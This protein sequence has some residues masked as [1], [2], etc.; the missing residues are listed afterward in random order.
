META[1]HRQQM[2]LLIE[3][4]ETWLAPRAGGYVGGDMFLYFSM[5]QVRNQDFRGPDFFLVLDVP[6]TERKS[7]V[8]WEEGKGPD[9]VIELL[10]ETTAAA[11]KGI[12]KQIY[13]NQLKVLEYYW[14]DPFNPEDWAGF[15]L[16][17]GVYVP[18]A[19]NAQQ[20]LISPLL[21]LA[22]V[23]WHGVYR[24]M[25]AT[26]L[27]WATVEGIL[28]PTEAEAEAQRADAEKQ[29]ADAAEAEVARLK[30]LLAERT[31]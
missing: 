24:H 14:Y 15:T 29:R 28:L 4:M 20:R 1:R 17:N 2:N 25:E 8:V 5:Q 21:D 19:P 12:K 6:R 23:R 18:L 27:R 22:L 3:T 9:V 10:S 26:W 31:A 30:A 11:D 16:Q 13:Q 7:W